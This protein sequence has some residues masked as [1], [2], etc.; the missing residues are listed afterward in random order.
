M[1]CTNGVK[2]MKQEYIISAFIEGLFGGIEKVASND[3]EHD[4]LVKFASIF[5]PAFDEAVE[6]YHNALKASK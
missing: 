4:R 3:A 5:Y 1:L 6:K 2:N